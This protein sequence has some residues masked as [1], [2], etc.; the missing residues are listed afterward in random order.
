MPS[1]PLP[2]KPL[3]AYGIAPGASCV[4]VGRGLINATWEVRSPAGAFV[5]QR[6]SPIFDP[7][8]HENIEA[9]TRRLEREGLT[10]PRLVRTRGGHLFADL[11]AEGIWRLMTHVPGTVHDAVSDPAEAF[12]AGALVARF[13]A[14]LADIDHTFVGVRRGVHDTAAHLRHLEEAVATLRGHRLHEEVAR[15]A[16]TILS[17]AAALEPLPVEIAP[18]P[19]HGDLKINNVVFREPPS[20]RAEAVCL[21]DLDTLAPLFL[22]HELGDAWR[23]WCNPAGEDAEETTFDAALFE[24][25]V[26]GYAASAVLDITPEERHGLLLG[27]E[28][29]PL[30]LAARFAA[31]ALVE[32]YFGWDPERFP[33]R[34]E[35]DLVRAR[36]QMGVFRAAV[37]TRGR[38]ERALRKMR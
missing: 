34:G 26:E 15:L 23:S 12:A 14:A 2:E 25:A 35:H 6:V 9:V 11:G 10:T 3:E 20:H 16:E 27:V 31:D 21:I 33:G 5:L 19:G 32:S 22:H 4:P 24:A 28:W 17:A 37:A 13:H 30:E 1:T 29:I 36:G 8:I 18:R 7:A 38:R